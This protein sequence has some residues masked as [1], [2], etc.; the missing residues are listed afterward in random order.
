MNRIKEGMVA[1]FF[2]F[3]T[4]Y[5]KVLLFLYIVSLRKRIERKYNW[6]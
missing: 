4:L 3:Y 2:A 6:A 1:F 5:F